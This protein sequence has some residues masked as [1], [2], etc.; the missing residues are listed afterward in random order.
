[1]EDQINENLLDSDSS[2]NFGLSVVT[3]AVTDLITG[4]TIPAPI[5][6]NV[7]KAFDR[8]C[9]AAIDVPVAWLEGKSAEKRAETQARVKLIATAG[10]QIAKQMNVEPEYAQSAVKKYG[11]KILREQINLDKTCEVAANQIK[12]D[13][14]NSKK[15]LDESKET[16]SIN[17]DWLNN[18]E[19]EASLKSTEEMQL[20][21]GRI[22]AGEIQQPDSFSIKTV[23]L[24]ASLDDKVAKLFQ[25]FCS[26][27]VSVEIGK[28]IFDTR[29][30]SLGGN[31]GSNALKDYD[32][33][34]GQL[35]TLHEYG[36]IIPDYNSW[37]NYAMS[38]VNEN[39]QIT[40]PFKY[41]NQN[42]AFRPIN[43]RT[44]DQE[45][46]LHGV[47]LSNTGKELMKIVDI[48]PNPKYT[49]AFE[50]YLKSLDIQKV[51]V[52]V[53]HSNQPV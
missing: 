31:A 23:K 41:Q 35:N 6:K 1:M 51:E 27:C 21:F 49:T 34:F 25:Q 45:L 16:T 3:D 36:L 44:K 48:E 30:V 18:F 7:F 33:S 14:E 47:A 13:V 46:R 17:D 20:L 52:D 28:E 42:W 43:N 10:D 15:V 39:N 4:T 26:L 9:S 53:Y 24:L 38:I 37:Y 12:H 19:K 8:L 11:Q 2:E 32:L 40:L 5:R 29:V 22:L 50:E